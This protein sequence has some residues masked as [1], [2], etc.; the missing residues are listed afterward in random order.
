MVN[1]PIRECDTKYTPRSVK[2]IASMGESWNFMLM[3][4]IIPILHKIVKL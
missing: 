2:V 4:N 3:Q 1:I